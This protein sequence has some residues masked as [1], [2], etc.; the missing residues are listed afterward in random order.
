MN[1]KGFLDEIFVSWQGEGAFA[2]VR[3]IFIRFALC[4]LE[5]SY[6]DTAAAGEIKESFSAFGKRKINN[7]VSIDDVLK[8]VKG[9]NSHVHSVSLTGGEP[10]VQGEFAA[11]LAKGLKKSGF[12]VYLETNGTLSKHLKNILPF[13]DVVAMDIKL[14]SAS[15]QKGLWKKHIKFLKL[16]G[17][18][19]FVKIV[20]SDK[21]K[22]GDITKAVRLA[23]NRI[24]ILQPEYRSNIRKVIKLIDKCRNF[25]S[26]VDIRL[27]PQIHRYIGIR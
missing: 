25:K 2:G 22:P 21:T 4:N 8:I 20:I 13:T 23:K 18:K 1:K 27:M 19:A 17:K 6:C 9:F 10:L 11:L 26:G 7:P 16:A 12:K 24:I 3:Q 15:G 5:C 14:P